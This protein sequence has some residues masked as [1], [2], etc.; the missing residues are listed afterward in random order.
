[1]CGARQ[2]PKCEKDYCHYY[3]TKTIM[4]NNV[5]CRWLA[6]LVGWFIGWLFFFPSSAQ[7][8]AKVTWHHHP[9]H[10]FKHIKIGNGNVILN[11]DILLQA[12][13]CIVLSLTLAFPHSIAVCQHDR[14]NLFAL[15]SNVECRILL[16]HPFGSGVKETEMVRVEG[17]EDHKTV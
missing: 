1:M 3:S 16:S 6:G 15:H 17:D 5:M 8:Y 12:Y 14:A 4:P 11:C 9:N 2:M 13:T 10:I 7:P